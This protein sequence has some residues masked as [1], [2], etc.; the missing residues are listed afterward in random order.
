MNIYK[1]EVEV[2]SEFSWSSFSW[3]FLEKPTLNRLFA[4]LSKRDL[5]ILDAGCGAGRIINYLIGKGVPTSN[6]FG[7][8][9][10]PEMIKM[11]RKKFSGIT[12]IQG[13]ITKTELRDNSIDLIT[14]TMVIH[15]L[16]R[17]DFKRTLG[18]FYR[19]L[20]KGGLLFYMVSHPIRIIHGDMSKY[21]EEGWQ[22]N[23]TPWGTKLPY[24]HRTLETYINETKAAGFLITD[25]HEPSLPSNSKKKDSKSYESYSKYPARLAITAIKI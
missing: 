22:M 6:I 23:K 10:S 4:K 12:F 17:E 16:D 2:Y 13:N 25:L 19:L 3:K 7:Q 14:C 20:K 21:F 11:A 8:D 24:F 15:D 9:I 5:K 1:D 18:N